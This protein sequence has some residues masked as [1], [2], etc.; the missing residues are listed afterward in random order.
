M[1]ESG[2]TVV[3][4]RRRNFFVW[5]LTDIR[6]VKGVYLIKEMRTHSATQYSM[7][8]DRSC[9]I[10]WDTEDVEYLYKNSSYFFIYKGG[11]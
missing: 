8:W 10:P 4:L 1:I 7:Y 6:L 2:C 5:Y 3:D 9:D 11:L